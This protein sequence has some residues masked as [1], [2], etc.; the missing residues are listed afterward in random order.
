M[1]LLDFKSFVNYNISSLV[2]SSEDIFLRGDD[3]MEPKIQAGELLSYRFDDLTSEV[4]RELEDTA[5]VFNLS[6]SDIEHEVVLL[7]SF[8][9]ERIGASVETLDIAVSGKRGSDWVSLDIADKLNTCSGKFLSYLLGNAEYSRVML[10]F[11]SVSSVMFDKVHE[12]VKPV[13]YSV[14]TD[15]FSRVKDYPVINGRLAKYQVYLDKSFDEVCEDVKERFS[16]DE[17]V[18]LRI[19][20]GLSHYCQAVGED[21]TPLKAVRG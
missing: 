11:R 18:K 15:Y 2:N 1:E 17:A 9:D 14:A 20:E 12:T 10:V 16:S 8:A 5:F 13:I 21:I 19:L 6:K 3:Y 7:R 4:F